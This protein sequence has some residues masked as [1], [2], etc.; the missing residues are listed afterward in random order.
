M[1]VLSTL[2]VLA[3]AASQASAHY[4]WTTITAGGVSTMAAIRQPLNN[5]PVEAVSSSAMVCNNNPRPATQTI[6]V[7]AGSQVSFKLDNTLYHSGPAAIYLG[8][9]PSGQTAASWNGAGA[10]WFKIAE[11]GAKFNP[12]K[13]TAEGLSTLSATIPRNAPSGEYLIRIEHIGLHV[14][15]KPQF[16][17]SCAQARVTGGGS[18]RPPTVSIP[19]YVS[20]SDPG[21]SVNIYNPVPTSYKVPGPAVW[22]G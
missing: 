13:F 10:N 1:K 22:S 14:A 16:Y 18:G 2:S 11:W 15:G 3:F 4:I 6:D 21:L 19:G 5:T 12:F 8:L 20:M 7:A 9:V 17:I